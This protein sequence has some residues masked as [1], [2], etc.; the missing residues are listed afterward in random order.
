MI[1]DGGW[2]YKTSDRYVSVSGW[3]SQGEVDLI[4]FG[5][6]L[7]VRSIK[8]TKMLR[9]HKWFRSSVLKHALLRIVSHLIGPKLIPYL[10]EWLIFKNEP[11][12]ISLER[13]ICVQEDEVIIEDKI[14][15]SKN[16]EAEAMLYRSGHYSSYHVSS[17]GTFHRVEVINDIEAVH[18]RIKRKYSLQ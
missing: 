2:R 4:D 1:F 16:G 11:F 14:F 17:A 10:K 6:T 8:I 3:Q 7:K 18:S 12:F 15:D 13:S 5:G 9:K